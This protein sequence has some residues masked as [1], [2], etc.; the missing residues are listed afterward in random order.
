MV[1][2]EFRPPRVAET[3]KTHHAAAAS[4][5]ARVADRAAEQLRLSLSGDTSIERILLKAAAGAGKSYV[6]KRLVAE[7][8]DHSACA[9]VAGLWRSDW[10]RHWDGTVCACS[11]RAIERRNCRTM[12]WRA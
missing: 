4:E 12:C 3:G 9:R 1:D 6:M 10:D 8:L 5:N 11:S 7:A 2:I